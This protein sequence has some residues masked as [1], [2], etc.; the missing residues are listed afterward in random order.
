MNENYV[1]ILNKNLR[2]E[3]EVIAKRVMAVIPNP[4]DS[5][6][7]AKYELFLYRSNRSSRLVYYFTTTVRNTED[8]I[9]IMKDIFTTRLRS[10]KYFT[11]YKIQNSVTEIIYSNYKKKFCQNTNSLTMDRKQN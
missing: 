6:E 8:C 11:I 2:T 1:E 3:L 4:F 5:F 10:E 7:K 9:Q